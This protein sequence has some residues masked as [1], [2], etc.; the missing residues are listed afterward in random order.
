AERASSGRQSRS[1]K[2]QCCCAGRRKHSNTSGSAAKTEVV[3]YLR[4]ADR[5]D[6]AH[7]ESAAFIDIELA[8]FRNR[9]RKKRRTGSIGHSWTATA[10]RWQSL[11]CVDHSRD[12][13]I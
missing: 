9:R 2:Q 5:R 1:I 8:S 3:G 13:R 4:L 12:P 6:T 11:H 7:R 10:D